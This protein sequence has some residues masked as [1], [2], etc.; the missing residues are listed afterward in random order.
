MIYVSR[1]ITR[2]KERWGQGIQ[3]SK[4][5][6]PIGSTRP[7]LVVGMLDANR[8]HQDIIRQSTNKHI[9][10]AVKEDIFKT[11]A[12]KPVVN[13]VLKVTASLM[14]TAPPVTNV[15]RGNIKIQ[16]QTRIA[17]TVTQANTNRI[18][19]KTFL[20]HFVQE[21]FLRNNQQL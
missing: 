21:D 10:W 15:L 3:T 16:K 18:P 1:V 11:N 12:H 7:M 4:R 14:K 5:A 6:E 17:S 9:V 20:V 2:T 8:A 19:S 13:L